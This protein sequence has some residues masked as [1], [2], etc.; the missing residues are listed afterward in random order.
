VLLSTALIDARHDGT[1]QT[2]RALLDSGSQSNF[3]TEDLVRLLGLTTR[4][5]SIPVVRIKHSWSHAQEIVKVKVKS[6]HCAFHIEIEC[7]VLKRISERLPNVE[8]DKTSFK[9]P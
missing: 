5:I 2:C 9:L 7:L 8:L 4:S 3:I 6:R 1:S